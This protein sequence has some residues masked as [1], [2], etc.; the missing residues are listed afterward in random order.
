MGRV[1]YE[2]MAASPSPVESVDFP[3]CSGVRVY[4]PA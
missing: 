4:R 2:Q 1:T 3:D